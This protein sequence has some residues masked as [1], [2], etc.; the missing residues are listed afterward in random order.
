MA[1]TLPLLVVGHKNPDTD[2]ILSALA[3][4]D[5][6]RQQGRRALAIAQGLP[7][8]ETAFVL[9]RCGIKAP[10]VRLS[11]GRHPVMLVDHSDAALAPDDLS[12]ANLVGIV[13]HH[14]LGGL[15]SDAP[16]LVRIAPVGSTATLI[17]DLYREAGQRIPKPLACGLLGA[18]LSD[19]R[20]FQSPT[21]TP[22]DRRAAQSLATQAGIADPNRF[23]AEMLEAY[24]AAMARRSDQE[25]I[26]TDFK[27]FA[28]GVGR[29]GIA[30]IEAPDIG[31]V[32]QRRVSL[33]ST[34]EQERQRLGLHSLLLMATDVPRQGTE[35]IVVSQDPTRIAAALQLKLTQQSGWVPGMMSRKRQVVP[36]LQQALR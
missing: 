7:N 10:P 4:A 3:M 13:D 9:S 11:V 29:I 28:M 19:T 33:L 26:T 21:T 30:Q 6:E 20:S 34:M 36:Q 35:L 18:V 8:P 24:A 17:V 5:L 12:P 23:G 1:I 2:A 25:L 31:F 27:I 22:K 32:L 16:P 15:Q 14:K